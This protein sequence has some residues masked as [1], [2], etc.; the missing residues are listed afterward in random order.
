MLRAHQVETAD[1][2]GFQGYTAPPAKRGD[3]DKIFALY[4]EALGGT[5]LLVTIKPI[6]TMRSLNT[7]ALARRLIGEKTP[8]ITYLRSAFPLNTWKLLLRYDVAWLQTKPSEILPG[9]ALALLLGKSGA[10][11]YIRDQLSPVTRKLLAAYNGSDTLDPA[12]QVALA[13]EINAHLLRDARFFRKNETELRTLNLPLAAWQLINSIY[14]DLLYEHYAHE[15]DLDRREQL[16]TTLANAEP[17]ESPVGDDMVR[18]NRLLLE[19]A[20]PFDSQ[21]PWGFRSRRV[22]MLQEVRDVLVDNFNAILKDQDLYSEER[23]PDQVEDYPYLQQRYTNQIGW[24]NRRLLESAFHNE[25]E[26]SDVPYR[27]RLLGLI[28]V[29]RSGAATRQ[30]ILDIVA[31]NLGI[32]GDDPQVRAARAQIHIEEFAPQ[33]TSFFDGRLSLYQEFEINDTNA[34]NET[35][36]IWVKMLPGAIKKLNNIRFIDKNTFKQVRVATR[37]QANDTLVFKASGILLN[38]VAPPELAVGT[39]PTLSSK[40]LHWR[41]EADLVSPEDN[42]NYPAGLF[43]QHTFDTVAWADTSPIV[44]VQ[45]LSYR[46]TPGIFTVAIPWHIPGF[47]DKFAETAEHP[48]HQILTLVNRVK[49]AGVLAQVAYRQLFSE[50]HDHEEHLELRIDRSSQLNHRWAGNSLLDETHAIQDALWASN[51]QQ[52]REDQDATDALSLS[53]RFDLTYF[54]SLNTFAR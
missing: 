11:R 1:N 13:N 19:A 34:S 10:A 42:G 32:I 22:P 16:L 21:H 39:I 15:P 5:A 26:Q 17:A 30:G 25:L 23:F 35:P 9:F 28:R 18:L 50:D 14:R 43:D 49:A 53:G 38:G 3:L 33:L 40:S 29:L 20:F 8:L 37:L 47:T 54:D 6:F 41:F 45:V 48:R 7:R 52:T 44:N 4:L 46:Y 31:A 36:E 2:E 12:L 51:T 27:E 24:L